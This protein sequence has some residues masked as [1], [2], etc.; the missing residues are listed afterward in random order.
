MRKLL[1]LLIILLVNSSMLFSQIGINTDG[2]APDNSA[3]LDIKS[4]SKGLLPPR[5]T[6][7]QLN[8]ISN[9][10]DGLIVFCTDCGPG[11]SG[12]LVMYMAGL[13]YKTNANCLNPLSPLESEHV[14]SENQIQWNW[15]SVIAAT[16]YKW[17]TTN[18]YVS[19]TDMGASATYTESELNCNDSYTRYAWAYNGCGGY[20]APVELTES[21]LACPGCGTAITINHVA[22]NIAPVT[23]TVTYGIVTNIP[24]EVS[25][26]WISSNLGASNQA[27]AVDDN[28]ELPA[29]WY[30]QFNRMQGYQHDGT[31]RTPSSWISNINENL[32]WQS[33]SDPCFLEL[34]NGWRIPTSVEWTNI[35]ASGGWTDWTGPWTSPL[36]LHAAGYLGNGDL[37][38]RSAEGY[39]WSSMQAGTD[40]ESGWDLH[41]NSS[42]SAISSNNKKMGFSVRCIKDICLSDPNAPSSGTHVPSQNQIQWKWNTVTDAAGYKWNSTNDYNTA[43]DVGSNVT[44]TESGLNCNEAYTS[45]V[46][47]YNACTGH[48]AAVQLTESTLPC[49]G[50]GTSMTIYHQYGN[51]SAITRTVTYEIVTNIPGETSKCWISTNLGAAHQATAV[52]DATEESAGWYWQFNRLQGYMHDGYYGIMPPTGWVASI[53]ENLDWQSANDP[54]VQ[55]LDVGWRIPTSTEWTN[56]D[57]S[58][59]WT[60][61]NGPWNSALKLHAAGYVGNQLLYNRGID[62]YYWS[63]KQAGDDPQSGWDLHMNSS[64]SA[65]SNNGK[66]QGFSVRCIKEICISAPTA[67][68]SGTHVPLQTQITWNWNNISGAVGYKWNTTNNYATAIDM[69]PSLTKTETELLCNTPYSRYAWAYNACGHSQEVTLNQATN[70][71]FE[72]PTVSTA[73]VSE[74]SQLTATSGGNVTSEGGGAVT[75]RG[76]CWSTSSNPTTTDT[77]TI[78]G[79]GTG[80]FVSHLT[81]LTPETL[82]YV[83]AY[84]INSSGTSYGNEES[85]TTAEGTFAFA[86]GGM[87]ADNAYAVMHTSD[88]GFAIAGNTTSWGAGG[89]DQ[90]LIKTNSDGILTWAGAY[91]VVND[92]DCYGAIQRSDGGYLLVGTIRGGSQNY[93]YV[94]FIAGDGS[95]QNDGYFESSSGYSTGYDIIQSTDGNFVAVGYIEGTGIGEQDGY[96]NKFDNAGGNIWSWYWGTSGTEEIRAVVQR[97]DGGYITV[98]FAITGWNQEVYYCPI[99][100]DGSLGGAYTI[101]G[102]GTEAATSVCKALDDAY[103]FSGRT[104]SFGAGGSDVYLRK[105]TVSAE[106]IWSHALGGT[107]YDYGYDVI[108]T[109]DGGFA[110]A[111]FTDSFGAGMIDVWLIKTDALGNGQWSWVFGGW[112]IE[113][114]YSVV[115]TEDGCYYVAGEVSTFTGPRGADALLVKFAADGSACLGYAVGFNSNMMPVEGNDD[116]FEAKRIDNFTQTTILDN[117]KVIRV[118]SSKVKQNFKINST[119]SGVFVTPSVTTICD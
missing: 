73:A 94:S 61:W 26:C 17:N 109:S 102:S 24:G 59:G 87:G 48:S 31:T 46:W 7:D 74:I 77:K 28:T 91:G 113:Y 45:F 44:F 20:S 89:N 63:N 65:M 111:G 35:D 90:L 101:G 68:S 110:V 58:G 95:L 3:M 55:L 9:P 29:G 19:A 39:Y 23:K 88:G 60:D 67:P 49:P 107:G 64:Y 52:N 98:G 66:N 115:Q 69:G 96:I 83:R 13:W 75:Q 62:G 119:R 16:G 51:I 81:G 106:S 114:G 85:F 12:S 30:W 38:N 76:V 86:Y 108:R 82:Y 53:N 71:C 54:C 18:D 34:G 40:F 33:A 5:M 32:D 105:Q 41:L 92:E 25:K 15:N 118:N 36:K 22:G 2:G 78:N 4:T 103:V 37:Y 57:A 43:T 72:L 42:S 112:A 100:P 6:F 117:A 97:P 8:A 56:V 1:L 21:T 104:T 116:N 10:A 27:M 50:C 84:A 79:S 80:V 14:A 70:E 47:A 11:N 93:M 99:N